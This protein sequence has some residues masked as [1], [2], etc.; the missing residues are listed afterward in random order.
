MF[1]GIF[2]FFFLNRVFVEVVFWKL[3]N[4]ISFCELLAVAE[5]LSNVSNALSFTCFMDF[6]FRKQ[7]P[8]R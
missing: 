5:D 3:L 4:L 2:F 1:A 6:F 8:K 7:S